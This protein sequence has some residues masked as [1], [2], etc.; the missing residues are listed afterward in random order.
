MYPFRPKKCTSVLTILIL[1]TVIYYLQVVLSTFGDFTLH[2]VDLPV[3][4]LHSGT[5][6]Q[7]IAGLK[8]N[9]SQSIEPDTFVILKR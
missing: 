8:K 3:Q 4:V 7:R 2:I 1:I 9:V 5:I 6:V